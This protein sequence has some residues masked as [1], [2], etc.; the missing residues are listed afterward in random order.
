MPKVKKDNAEHIAKPIVTL[1]RLNELYIQT[2]RQLGMEQ[3]YQ[4]L[5]ASLSKGNND[6]IKHKA[7]LEVCEVFNIKTIDLFNPLTR[8]GVQREAL[9]SLYLVL[10]KFIPSYNIQQ[11]VSTT[12]LKYNRCY[13]II[14]E[15]KALDVNILPD[16]QLLDKVDLIICHIIDYLKEVNKNKKQSNKK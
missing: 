2:Y 9:M 3:T 7:T 4:M 13:L 10:K 8:G 6:L 16:K 5:K 11:Y 14:N 15:S 1:D 12:G